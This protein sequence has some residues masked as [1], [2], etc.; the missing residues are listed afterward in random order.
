MSDLP[1]DPLFDRVLLRRPKQKQ[2]GSIVV[3]EQYAKRNAPT[4]GT[5]VA[6]GPSCDSTV[7][8]GADYVF[9]IHAGTW[10]N[11]EGMAVSNDDEA[12]FFVCVDTDLIAKVTHG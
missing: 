12:E 7:S 5:C 8:V 3:P 2:I 11:A 4:R 1:L 6:K 9:G 10:I